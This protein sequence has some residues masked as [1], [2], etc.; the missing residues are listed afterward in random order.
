MD[1]SHVVPSYLDAEAL[2]AVARRAGVTAIHPGYGFLAEDPDFARAVVHAG[3]A[4]V[5]PPPEAIAAMGDKAAARRRAGGFVPIVPGYDG[6]AQDDGA[7]L[8]EADLVG[9]P[10]LV[11]PSAGGGQDAT[12]ATRR[13]FTEALQASRREAHRSFADDRLV[14]E[15]YLEGSRHVEVQV[16]FDGHGAGVHLGERDCSAQRRSQKIVEEVLGPSV[17]PEL[18]ERMTGAALALAADVGYIGAG[19]VEMLVTDAGDFYFLEMN[20]RLQVEHPVTEAVTGRDLVADQLRIAGGAT[21]R[22]W[23]LAGRRGSEATPSRRGCT[24]RT[25]RPASCPPPVVSRASPGRMGSDR[26]RSRRGRCGRRP[27]RSR[28]WPC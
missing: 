26:C 13:S 2:V 21:S 14:L 7:L 6:D 4:W 10:L 15:R 16:L 28:C 8:R 27:I 25:R 17:T 23:A 9:F 11:K 22:S 3:I 19:T 1:E 18:R 5:G 24:P 12:S 20:T